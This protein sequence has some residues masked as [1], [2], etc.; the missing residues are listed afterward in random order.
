MLHARTCCIHAHTHT[1]I[2]ATLT[3]ISFLNAI[4][5]PGVAGVKVVI[6]LTTLMQRRR[7]EESV[8]LTLR[9]IKR[10]NGIHLNFKIRG[11]R[12]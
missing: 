10:E 4:Q 12:F 6:N 8:R 9:T 11:E 1:H 5:L 2:Y 3:L 7:R